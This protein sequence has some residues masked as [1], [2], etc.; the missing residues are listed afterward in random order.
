MDVS[1]I[2]VVYTE[3]LVH[4]V[5]CRSEVYTLAG[6]RSVLFECV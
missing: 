5:I 4:N 3:R 2:S 1:F 6:L